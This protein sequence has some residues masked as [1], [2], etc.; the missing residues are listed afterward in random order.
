MQCTFQSGDL[1]YTLIQPPTIS[2]SQQVPFRCWQMLSTDSHSLAQGTLF[3]LFFFLL[4]NGQCH[5]GSHGWQYNNNHALRV[6]DQPT[7][8]MFPLISSMCDCRYTCVACSFH[9]VLGLQV[10][11]LFF[12]E[13]IWVT[14]SVVCLHLRFISAQCK[15]S[16]MLKE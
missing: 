10:C 8:Y 1:S 4:S 9:L 11:S 5:L 7:Y 3:E 2:N 6:V 15:W 13:G 14:R 12:C 16:A